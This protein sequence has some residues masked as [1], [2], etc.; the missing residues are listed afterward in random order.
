MLGGKAS[1]YSCRDLLLANFAML[2]K[3][4]LPQGPRISL[5]HFPGQSGRCVSKEHHKGLLRY[6]ARWPRQ[7][8]DGDRQQI[9]RPR[10]ALT[11]V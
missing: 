7:K 11:G 10:K 1:R 5:F 8:P 9:W 4:K 2:Y 6:G 3:F